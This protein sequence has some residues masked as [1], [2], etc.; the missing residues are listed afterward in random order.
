[1]TEEQL[2]AQMAL[3][4][5]CIFWT[6]AGAFVIVVLITLLSLVGL[7]KIPSAAVRRGLYSVLV[8]NLAGIG[9]AA[10]Q[11]EIGVDVKS[12]LDK[13]TEPF[14]EKLVA[15]EAE[16]EDIESYLV[17]TMDAKE[18]AETELATSRAELKSMRA[19]TQRLAQQLNAIDVPRDAKAIKKQDLDRIRKEVQKATAI[20]K[21]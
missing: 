21:P 4:K 13:I 17:R 9:V 14:R 12:V 6:L 10:F 3:M 18:A 19:E 20:L 8:V 1:M 15:V 7:I 2:A 11:A 16:K 5:V